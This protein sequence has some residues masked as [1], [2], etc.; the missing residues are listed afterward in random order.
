MNPNKIVNQVMAH[1]PQIEDPDLT[2][3]QTK[4]LNFLKTQEKPVLAKT[5]SKETDIDYNTARARLSELMHMGFVCQPN[6]IENFIGNVS[7]NGKA[8]SVKGGL[9]CGYSILRV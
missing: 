2:E 5:I 3:N 7:E 1:I 9:V 6:K 8:K 4:I